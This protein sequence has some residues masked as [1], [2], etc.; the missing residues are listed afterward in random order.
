MSNAGCAP[1]SCRSNFSRAEFGNCAEAAIRVEPSANLFDK[2]SRLGH[3][4][5]RSLWHLTLDYDTLIR[6]APTE[7]V[8]R[9]RPPLYLPS[10]FAVAAPNTLHGRRVSVAH[11]R[12]LAEQLEGDEVVA[13]ADVQRSQQAP[14]AIPPSHLH[15]YMNSTRLITRLLGC[16]TFS[17]FNIASSY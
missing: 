8:T 15:L 1:L 3:G 12:E 10:S 6:P 2:A 9:T 4:I 14:P 17:S 11:L 16:S 5:G 7:T 13:G